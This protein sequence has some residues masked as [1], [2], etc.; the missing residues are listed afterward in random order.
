MS[1]IDPVPIVCTRSHFLKLVI[2]MLEVCVNCLLV[3][4]LFS[5]HLQLHMATQY[6]KNDKHI[7]IHCQVMTE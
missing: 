4:L 7:K 5:P 1:C 3:N 6:D 2:T